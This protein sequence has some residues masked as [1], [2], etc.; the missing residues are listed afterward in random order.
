[1]SQECGCRLVGGVYV[2]PGYSIVKCTLCKAAPALLEA[3]RKIMRGANFTG[4]GFVVN[5]LPVL[6]Q[7]MVE[8]SRAIEAASKE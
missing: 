3:A 7:G 8:M 2:P 6:N 5:D 1:M 4:L